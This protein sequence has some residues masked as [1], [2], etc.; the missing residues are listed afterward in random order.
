MKD[1]VVNFWMKSVCFWHIVFGVFYLLQVITLE[2]V[3][4]DC[5]CNIFT[6]CLVGLSSYF[7]QV[8]CSDTL[9]KKKSTKN[10]Q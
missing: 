3:P 2:N 7:N 9:Q 10:I 5:A 1:L 8:R 6:V 4:T